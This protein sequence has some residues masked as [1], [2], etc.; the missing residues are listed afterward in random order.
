M[1]T[2]SRDRDAFTNTEIALMGLTEKRLAR[3]ALLMDMHD[4]HNVTAI[5][6]DPR[7]RQVKTLESHVSH[8]D[9]YLKL[10]SLETLER[11]KKQEGEPPRLPS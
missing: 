10:L 11:Y 6:K 2:D 5:I 7:V 9:T 8:G 1:R 4:R 3:Q